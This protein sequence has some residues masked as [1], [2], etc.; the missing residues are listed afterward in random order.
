MLCDMVISFNV[1]S[2]AGYLAQWCYGLDMVCH[3][4]FMCHRCGPQYSDIEVV[5]LLK[6]G[7]SR[8]VF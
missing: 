4:G 8:E 3:R 2:V 6:G 5:R 1:G 7:A